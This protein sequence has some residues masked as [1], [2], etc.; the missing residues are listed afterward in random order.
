MPVVAT[1][2][3]HGLFRAVVVSRAGLAGRWEARL[4]LGGESALVGAQKL[5]GAFAILEDFN[6]TTAASL[7]VSVVPEV[8]QLS[9]CRR[10]S[11]GFL[12]KELGLQVD[13]L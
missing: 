6:E 10:G 9:C 11:V 7:V 5:C 3:H 2:V 8:L 4:L 1:G 13:V 12:A